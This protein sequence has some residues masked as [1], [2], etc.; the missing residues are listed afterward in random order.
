MRRNSVT[1]VVRVTQI[2]LSLTVIKFTSGDDFGRTRKIQIVILPSHRQG[3]GG[4]SDLHWTFH[5]ATRK[6]RR[7][8]AGRSCP[9]AH[10]LSRTTLEKTYLDGMPVNRA[11]KRHVGAMRKASVA[12]DGCA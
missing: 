9:G 6:R 10:G 12:F 2:S 5:Q 4:G 7:G 11:D 3:P 1:Q 8:S